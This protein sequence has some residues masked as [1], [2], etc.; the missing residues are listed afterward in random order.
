MTSDHTSLEQTTRLLGLACMGFGVAGM[1]APGPLRRSY[2]MSAEDPG[3]ELTYLGRM[4]GTRTLV[5]GAFVLGA[6]GAEAQRR[7]LMLGAG[8]N[9]FDA[10]AAAST[11]GL[12]RRTKVMGAVTSGF[13][14]ASSVY[15]ATVV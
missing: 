3:G 14:A 7:A 15:G 10:L 9:A 1:V 8:L 12:P 2:G 13:F 11:R 4:W 5:V 6:Q